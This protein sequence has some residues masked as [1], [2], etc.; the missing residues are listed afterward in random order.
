MIKQKLQYFGYLMQSANRLEKI[1]MMGKIEGKRIRGQQRISWLD[2]ITD[3]MDMNLSKLQSGGQGS[4]VHS[5]P[6]GHKDLD[7]TWW[8]NNK[9]DVKNKTKQATHR[10]TK[11]LHKDLYMNVYSNFIWSSYRK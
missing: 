9:S 4:L 10:N 8:L 11:C 2:S 7:M 3:S 6:W 5:S 1:L